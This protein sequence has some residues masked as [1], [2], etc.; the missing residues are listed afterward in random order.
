MFIGGILLG[1]KPFFCNF[2]VICSI[3]QLVALRAGQDLLLSGTYLKVYAYAID[4]MRN[5]GDF[6]EVGY[7]RASALPARSCHF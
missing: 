2:F 5:I 1:A 3:L 7:T 4:L 6:L